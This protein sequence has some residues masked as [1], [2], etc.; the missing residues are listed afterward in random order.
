MF[1]FPLSGVG[2]VNIKKDFEITSGKRRKRLMR[3]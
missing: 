3:E 1:I 2:E